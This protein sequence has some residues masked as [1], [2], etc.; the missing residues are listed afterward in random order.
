MFLFEFLLS[1]LER[2]LPSHVQGK[3]IIY[4]A[5]SSF[6]MTLKKKTVIL[7]DKEDTKKHPR[8]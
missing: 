2:S 6:N 5:A 1:H 7:Y 8:E 4:I 3:K